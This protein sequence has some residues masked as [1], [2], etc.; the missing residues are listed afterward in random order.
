MNIFFYVLKCSDGTFYG[1]YTTDVTRREQEH[2]DGIR[3]KYT[4]TRR[5]VQVI[6]SERF[7]T[8]SEATKAEA[9]F[10]ALSRKAKETY[11]NEGRNEDADSEKLSK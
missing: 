5:P 2:N 3:C 6:H 1:G 11:L 9:R 7:A 4:K 10:K 8:R